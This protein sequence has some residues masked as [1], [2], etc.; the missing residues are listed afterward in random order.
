M[1]YDGSDINEE[2]GRVGMY[3]SKSKSCL[4]PHRA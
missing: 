3:L 2:K 1:L 4:S